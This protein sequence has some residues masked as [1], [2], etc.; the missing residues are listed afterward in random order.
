MKKN[1]FILTVVVLMSC[2]QD[3]ELRRSIFIQDPASPGLPVYSEWGYNTFGAY[4]NRDIFVSTDSQ[5]PLQVINHDNKTTFVFSGMLQ[6]QGSYYNY[7]YNSSQGPRILKVIFSDFHPSTYGD[8]IALNEEALDLKDNP[9]IEV[10]LEN[11]DSTA[12]EMQ[13]IS[14]QF[15][16]KRAQY[17]MVD[18]KP[19]EVILSGTFE[20][21]AL[22]NG[23]LVSISD[24]RFDTGI[25]NSNFFKY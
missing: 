1:I 19:S 14:G 12:L 20:F 3:F 23:E 15:Y 2:A 17:L 10:S 21:Q 24:G 5:V 16:F 18:K 8:L 7:N 25:S 22:I 6:P 11:S 9:S 13:I 4:Y